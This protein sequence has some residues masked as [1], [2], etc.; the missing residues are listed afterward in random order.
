M[1]LL[2]QLESGNSEDGKETDMLTKDIP[3]KAKFVQRTGSRNYR[4]KLS[5]RCTG[6]RT[7]SPWTQ[8]HISS[9][10]NTQ[11]TVIQ[12]M[13]F[14]PQSNPKSVSHHHDFLGGYTV[15]MLLQ[16]IQQ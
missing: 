4:S 8:S 10:S 9:I 15:I 11:N 6:M 13:N 5:D 12:N 1:F 16:N 14:S 3:L 7:P 2:K